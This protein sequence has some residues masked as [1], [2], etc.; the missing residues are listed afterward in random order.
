MATAD[1]AVVALKSVLKDAGWTLLE[2]A[3]LT[4]YV[5]GCFEDADLTDAD[6]EV[7]E[8]VCPLLVEAGAAADDEAAAELCKAVLQALSIGGAPVAA[9][10]EP[11]I[12]KLAGGPASMTQ[13]VK[14]DEAAVDQEVTAGLKAAT[15]VNVNDTLGSKAMANSLIEEDESEEAM[16]RRFKMAKR[17]DKLLKR[18]ARREHLLTMQREEVRQS[19]RRSRPTQS[20]RASQRSHPPA[21]ARPTRSS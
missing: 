7:S 10:A 6:G 17:G 4:D 21:I 19:A 5:A 16:R 12:K 9:A 2:E 18:A 8:A 14:A 1:E 20:Y 3:G 13:M 15:R 11:E